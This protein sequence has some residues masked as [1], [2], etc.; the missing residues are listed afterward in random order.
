MPLPS[1]PN[2]ISAGLIQNEFGRKSSAN[3]KISDYRR[4]VQ[5]GGK[6]W[7]LDEGIPTGSNDTIRFS[8][9][10]SKQHNIIIVMSG[11]TAYRQRILRDKTSIDSTGFRSTNSSVRRTSKNIVYIDRVIGSSRGVRE[12]VALRTQ[13]NDRWFNGSPNGAKVL[14]IVSPNGGLYGA[15]GNGGNGGPYNRDGENGENGTSALGLEIEVE[16]IEV[17]PGGII[18]GGGGGGAGGGG[19]KETSRRT[20]KAGGGGG[21][22]GAGL[23]PG[24]RGNGGEMNNPDEGEVRLSEP[25]GDATVISGGS[26]GEGGDNDGE[27]YGGGGGGGGSLNPNGS[28]GTGNDGEG[29]ATG[30]EDGSSSSGYGGDGGNGDGSNSDNGGESDGGRGGRG[31]YAITRKPGIPEPTLIGSDRIHGAKAQGGVA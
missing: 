8:D 24:E 31:G 13:P 15:G 18:V 12:K 10:H 27:A 1:S 16:S 22:G 17:K 14:I 30:G 25:G 19:G 20:R 5:I 23:P 9:F 4:S 29:G 3:W 21:G 6:N 2:K 11:N 28:P 26:G 7:P